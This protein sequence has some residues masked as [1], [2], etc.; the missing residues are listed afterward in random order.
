MGLDLI[1]VLNG[2]AQGMLLFLIAAGL[3]LIFGLMDVLNLA[4]GAVFAVGTYLALQFAPEGNGFLVA[5]AVAALAGALLGAALEAALRPIAGRGHIAEVLVTLGI[6]YVFLDLISIVWGDDVHSVAAP[7]FLQG[8]TQ[9]LGETYPTYRLAVIAFGLLVAGMMWLVFERTRLGAIVRAT[10]ADRPMVEALGIRT[11]RVRFG[12]FALGTALAAVGGVLAA[13]VLS[14]APGAAEYNLLLALII[15]VI[16]GLGSLRGAFVGALVVGQVQTTGVALF[17]QFAGFL[18]FGTM[19][20]ILLV[21]P[22]GLFGRQ[23][24]AR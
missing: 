18:L 6:T 10:V 22:Q 24:V 21:R 19:A 23:A 16:G 20:V 12:V 1:T 3:S 8:S 9:V 4:H 15:I 7:P 11:S 2:V 5:L 17:P 13:P 14:V